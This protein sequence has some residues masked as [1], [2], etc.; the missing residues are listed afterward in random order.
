[1]LASDVIATID[2][3]AAILANALLLLVLV[4]P[5]RSR[6]IIVTVTVLV[7][8]FDLSPLL[9]LPLRLYYHDPRS[10]GSGPC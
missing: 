7:D 9:T 8:M 10:Q 5:G 6:A 4:L 1:M 3:A 2:L